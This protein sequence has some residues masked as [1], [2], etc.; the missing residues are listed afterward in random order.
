[1]IKAWDIVSKLMSTDEAPERAHTRLQHGK[2]APGG[3]DS[4]A[5]GHSALTMYLSSLWTL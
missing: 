1:M 4:F 5:L 3:S 2:L